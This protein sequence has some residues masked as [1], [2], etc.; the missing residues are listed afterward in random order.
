MLRSMRRRRLFDP[1]DAVIW[2]SALALSALCGVGA[3]FALWSSL[4]RIGGPPF[5]RLLV[6]AAALALLGLSVRRPQIR[7]LAVVGCLALLA[8]FSF[9]AVLWGPLTGS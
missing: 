2:S 4:H 7:L 9:G 5:L 1:A 6:Y 8:S 3:G